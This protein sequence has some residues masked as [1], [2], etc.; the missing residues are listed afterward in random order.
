MKLWIKP[1]DIII[2]LLV[3]VLTFFTAY[4]A[5]MKPQG[6]AQVLIRGQGGE[7]T[8]PL[9]AEEIVVVAG[10]LGNTVVRLHENRA[11]IEA[12][13]CDNQNCVASGLLVRQG[14]WAACLPNNVLLMIHGIEDNDIDEIAW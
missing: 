5:Y 1:F 3:A 14:H 2:I 12:S 13:P 10:P 11:W 6:K 9:G 8:F 4:F 7:W